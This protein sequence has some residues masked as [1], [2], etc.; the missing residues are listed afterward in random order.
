MPDCQHHCRHA[1]AANNSWK[2]AESWDDVQSW[3]NCAFEPGKY[4]FRGQPCGVAST[5]SNLDRRRTGLEV[6][7]TSGHLLQAERTWIESFARDARPHLQLW[8]LQL[9]E[10]W[11]GAV[12]LMQHYGAPTRLLDWTRSP[13]V[14]LYF[15]L[16]SQPTAPK[17]GWDVLAFPQAALATPGLSDWQSNTA[18]LHQELSGSVEDHPQFLLDEPDDPVVWIEKPRRAQYDRVVLQQSVFTIS[19]GICVDHWDSLVA[20]TRDVQYQYRPKV[21]HVPHDQRW[22]YLRRLDRLG[23]SAARLMPGLQGVAARIAE[24]AMAYR[25]AAIFPWDLHQVSESPT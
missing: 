14:A 7:R 10:S 11:S 18:R 6:A 1:R 15:A 21:L 5:M 17:C 20:L 8:E 24:E 3:C 22:T 2:L 19:D 12:T 16:V 4:I 13:W 9:S 23:I 25:D